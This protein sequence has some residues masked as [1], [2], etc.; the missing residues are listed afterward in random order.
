MWKWRWH[1]FEF[2]EMFFLEPLRSNAFEFVA[3]NAKHASV[4]S[5]ETAYN[6]RLSEDL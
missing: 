3:S 6:V 5:E 1:E 4:P 2:P